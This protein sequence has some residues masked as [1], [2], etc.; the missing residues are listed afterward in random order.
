MRR[1]SPRLRLNWRDLGLL[2]LLA[3]T[4][5]AHWL[6]IDGV[7]WS[8]VLGVVLG[9]V[10][11]VWLQ[12]RQAPLVLGRNQ[13]DTAVV[14]Q[15]ILT[16]RQAFSVLT[17]QVDATIQAS[18]TAVMAMIERV[19]R[20]HHNAL[21]LQTK[22]HAAVGRSQALSSDSLS[23]AGQHGQA[24]A[25]LAKHQQVIEAQQAANQQRVR[26]VAVQVRQLTPLAALIADISRQTNLLAINASIEAARAGREG[27]GF[28]VVAASVRRLSQETAEAAQKISEGIH[29]SA[30]TIDE[31]MARADA[32]Q[33]DSAARQMGE[34]ATHIQLL[35]DTLGD[36]VPYLGQLSH[37]L[38][39]GMA[40]INDDVMDILAQMQFQD[41]NRQ[42][43]QQINAALATLSD[44]FAQI[45]SLIDGQAPPPPVMLEELLAR[46]TDNYVMHSQRVAHAAATARLPNSRP[47]GA[48]AP[49]QTNRQGEQRGEQHAE[50]QAELS[51]AGDR[52]ARIEFF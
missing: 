33:G 21:S 28:K 15:D 5:L 48:P 16:L 45:Y 52:G 13:R 19:N 32:Q 11:G 50:Q 26:A 47:D 37:H 34:I 36:V 2:G 20:V 40:T 25:T 51:L 46:W 43:L 35:S 24:V 18:E 6:W 22:I 29:K 17:Q 4:L 1:T 42:L 9:A 44:H 3:C 7:P 27:A 31:E 12:H 30:S 41:I 38:D 23:R 10:L 8:T 14:A 49:Q 39:T